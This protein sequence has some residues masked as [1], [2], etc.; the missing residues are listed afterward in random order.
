MEVYW[1]ESITEA[2]YGCEET[3][4]KVPT[5]LLKLVS[6][7]NPSVEKHVEAAEEVL[8]LKGISEGKQ[9][10]FTESGE[11]LKYI[12]VVAAVIR[13]TSHGEDKIFSTARGYGTYKG[14][15]EFPGGKIEKGETPEQALVREIHEE[16]TA[17]IKVGEL[18]KTI[19]YDYPEFHLSMDCFWAEI[20]N[21]SLIVK[22]AEAAKWLSYDELDS[23]SWLP[24]D[25]EL[26]DK[27]AEIWKQ[28]L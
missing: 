11:I 27:I 8:A 12:R 24:A 18:I 26:V 14:W 7:A 15:W 2:D 20:V 22:E 25:K 13:D 21:G 4:R 16:L 6:E 10:C 1:V 3:G 28:T 23:V 19:E 9:V 5:A 17:D